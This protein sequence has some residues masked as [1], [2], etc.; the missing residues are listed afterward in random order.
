MVNHKSVVMSLK[1][2]IMY[3]ESM[4]TLL[5]LC[6]L[7]CCCLRY[8]TTEE[9]VE[10]KLKIE[11]QYINALSEHLQLQSVVYLLLPTLVKT[12]KFCGLNV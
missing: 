11:I 1:D 2:V 5:S 6:G 3:S 7:V 9:N 4:H 10:E 12:V 8:V